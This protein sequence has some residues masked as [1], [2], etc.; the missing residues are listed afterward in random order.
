MGV[1][2]VLH[3]DIQEGRGSTLDSLPAF[4]LN[5][6]IE[7]FKIICYNIFVGAGFPVGCLCA[8]YIDKIAPERVSVIIFDVDDFKS[9]NDNY[10]HM[11]GDEALDVYK[12]Q[13]LRRS[14]H[15]HVRR[16]V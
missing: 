1:Y 6:L 11:K 10:S 5:F 8:L 9:Y 2:V 7:F 13:A 16:A 14:G 12:R 3:I 15:R 4:I